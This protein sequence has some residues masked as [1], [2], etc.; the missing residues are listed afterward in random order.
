LLLLGVML[1]LLLLDMLLLLLRKMLGFLRLLLHATILLPTIRRQD[2]LRLLQIGHKGWRGTQ[3]GIG[4][5]VVGYYR[6][7]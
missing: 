3:M 2:G 1:L 6:I 7:S 5:V 4:H